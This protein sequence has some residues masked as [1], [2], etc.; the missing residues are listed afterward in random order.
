MRCATG[1]GWQKIAGRRQELTDYRDETVANLNRTP[2]LPPRQRLESIAAT[3]QH[4]LQE[5]RPS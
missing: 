2:A 1:C 5:G 4:T 3:L